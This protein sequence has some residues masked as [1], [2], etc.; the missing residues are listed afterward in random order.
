VATAATVLQVTPDGERALVDAQLREM[1]LDLRYLTFTIAADRYSQ[2]LKAG[3]TP[4]LVA[5]M[6]AA[7]TDTAPS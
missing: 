2:E 3:R 1:S 4:S 6:Q 5:V 7:V